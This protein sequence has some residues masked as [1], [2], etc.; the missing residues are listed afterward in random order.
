M[1][2][3]APPARADFFPPWLAPAGFDAFAAGVV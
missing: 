3:R 1:S 2:R